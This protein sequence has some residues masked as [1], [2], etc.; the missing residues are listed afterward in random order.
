[1]PS[2]LGVQL[3][4]RTAW[5]MPATAAAMPSALSGGSSVLCCELLRNHVYEAVMTVLYWE[6]GRC[7]KG[8]SKIGGT[9]LAST[10][11]P[12]AAQPAIGSAAPLLAA[13]PLGTSINLQLQ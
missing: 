1:M 10:W 4:D 12:S 9:V 5:S 13:R 2:L 6:V 8:T 3:N 7:P 11:L